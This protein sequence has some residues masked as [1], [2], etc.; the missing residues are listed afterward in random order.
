MRNDIINGKQNQAKGKA[1]ETA[2]KISGNKG[3]EIKG[4]VEQASGKVQE[5]FGK[6][7]QNLKNRL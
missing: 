6:A 4:K 1:I 2:A 7:K 3:Q 5:E